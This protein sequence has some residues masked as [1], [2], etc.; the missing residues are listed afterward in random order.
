M[1]EVDLI[2][3][4]FRRR[5]GQRR[6]LQTAAWAFGCLVLVLLGARLWLGQALQGEKARLA[7]LTTAENLILQQRQTV[8]QLKARRDRLQEHLTLLDTL[9]GGPKVEQ[10]FV[11]LDRAI[12][13]AVWVVSW[14]FLRAGEKAVSSP[15]KPANGYLVSASGAATRP[16]SGDN[17][18]RMTINGQALSHSAL[19]D[20]VNALQDQPEIREVKLQ[21]TAEGPYRSG[22]AIAYELS[23]LVAAGE[24]GARWRTR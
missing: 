8:E 2:P 14:Q 13:E 18:I 9:R 10:L 21:S 1:A 15:V 3:A 7:A 4:D 19:A 16:E 23:V 6:R 12:N 17:E 22:L 5:Q 20:F 11:A 24:E